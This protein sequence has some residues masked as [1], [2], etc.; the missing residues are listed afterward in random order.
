MTSE[1]LNVTK[2][3]WKNRQHT[4][5]NY[6]KRVILQSNKRKKATRDQGV[7]IGKIKRLL[8]I[9]P[10]LE[11]EQQKHTI[12]V[13]DLEVENSVINITE[14]KIIFAIYNSV[15]WENHDLNKNYLN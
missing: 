14:H 5:Y 2:W 6:Q 15:C 9:C 11:L 10:P 8:S 4:F 12:V 1:G 7:Q 3:T 13:T